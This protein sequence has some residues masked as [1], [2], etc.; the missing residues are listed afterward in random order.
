MRDD[1]SCEYEV[2]KLGDTE[3]ALERMGLELGG[4][5]CVSGWDMNVEFASIA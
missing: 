1:Y 3:A 2:I 4:A 5:R